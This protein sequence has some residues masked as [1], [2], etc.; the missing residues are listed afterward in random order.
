MRYKKYFSDE[1]ILYIK[2]DDFSGST[3][4]IMNTI[5]DFLGLKYN[6][7]DLKKYNERREVRSVKLQYFI[8]KKLSKLIPRKFIPFFMK[9]NTRRNTGGGINIKTKKRLLE[10][11]KEDILKTAE[12]TGLDLSAWLEGL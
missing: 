11:Y 4:E 8:R 2:F 5:Y 1:N 7:I 6:D 12:L 9:L 3:S 10:R